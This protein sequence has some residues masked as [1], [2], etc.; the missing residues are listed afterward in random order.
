MVMVIS[1]EKKENTCWYQV[2][3][4]SARR[5][6]HSMMFTSMA[7][8]HRTPPARSQC[9]RAGGA[10][11]DVKILP[12]RRLYVET[13]TERQNFNVLSGGGCG[14]PS[15]FPPVRVIKIFHFFY[16]FKKNKIPPLVQ[17]STY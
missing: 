4:R 7:F 8:T 5:N 11:N 13:C 14:G 3:G 6:I 17:N 12:R 2:P 9:R 16:F 10:G 1:D 15:V